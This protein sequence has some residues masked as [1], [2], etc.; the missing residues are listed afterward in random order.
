MEEV[1][2]VDGDGVPVGTHPKATVHGV[3]TPRHLAFSCHVVGQD[4]RVL[5]TRRA[6]GKRTW[7]GVWTNSFCGHPQP[8]EPREEAVH[9]RAAFELGL[10]IEIL[11][12]PLPD[13]GYV[14]R[15]A[16]GIE[17]NEHCPVFVARALSEPSPHPDEV[18]ETRWVDPGE[19][20][21]GVGAAPWAFSPWLVEHLEAVLPHLTG[22]ARPAGH[23]PLDTAF[24]RR[25]DEIL[26]GARARSRRF[27]PSFLELWNAIESVVRGGKRIRPRLLFDAYRAMGGR[28]ESAAIDAACAVELLHAALITHDDVIDGDL[29]RR[30][31]EN[32]A[33]RF[34]AGARRAGASGHAA[35]TWGDASGIIAGDLLLTTAHGLI[36]GLDVDAPRRAAALAV[37]DDT[38]FES[39]AGEHS[40]VRLSMHLGTASPDEILT[41]AEQKTAPYSFR[42]PLLLGAL[43]AGATGGALDALDGVARDIGVIYQLRDDV[44]GTFGDESETGKSVLSD[45]R[46][47]KE[48]LLISYARSHPDWPGVASYVGDARLT[49]DEGERVR[50]V[51][52]TSGARAAVEALIGERRAAVTAR[53]RASDLP[54]ELVS[55]LTEVSESCSARRF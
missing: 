17:E 26:A 28:D 18:A 5:M 22:A 29:T 15:D 7:P 2:L 51:V 44:L 30:G 21:V 20:S 9:R 36:A 42:A 45:L 34:S 10:E 50:T 49:A 39:A 37:F 1:V 48:T 24:E 54:S 4:G 43:L 27:A 11:S 25:L 6:L 35:R 52:E 16:S 31:R 3:S 19:L 14:A 46:E 32:V 23:E 13:F 8:G 41:T 38:V 53:L 12:C 47:G 33:G 55:R 40:D